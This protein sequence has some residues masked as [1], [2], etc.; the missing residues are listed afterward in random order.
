MAAPRPHVTDERLSAYLDA[1]L[2][3]TGAAELERELQEL[4]EMRAELDALRRTID[5]VASL[6]RESA[7]PDFDAKL[8]RVLKRRRILD[9]EALAG[10]L[11]SM[12]FQVLSILVVLAVAAAYMFAELERVPTGRLQRVEQVAQDAASGESEG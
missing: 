11:I 10:N 1:E 6:P 9:I 2:D 8:A 4:P 7:P 3:P 12:P 5:L